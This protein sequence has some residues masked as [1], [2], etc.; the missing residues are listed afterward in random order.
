MNETPAGTGGTGS[1]TAI[2]EG[3]GLL[4]HYHDGDVQALRGVS[5]TIADGEFVAITGPSGCG[6]TT[7]LQ[8]L[9]GLDRPT[10]GDVLFRGRPLSAIDLDAYH[11]RQVGFVFQSFHL[12][13]TLTS[14]ENVQVPMFEGP[15]PRRERAPR[16]A[17]LLAEVGL[18]HRNAHRPGQLSVGERQRV[19]IAR[20]LAND[21]TLL[22]ADEPTGNLDSKSQVEILRLLA[23]LRHR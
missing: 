8:L 10:G 18:Q 1:E 4:K 19:A 22:L 12:L 16:A 9:G 20:A 11:A 14:V 7:L 5:M 21:P 2:L 17:A 6:K 3:R 15:W 13:P 23:D